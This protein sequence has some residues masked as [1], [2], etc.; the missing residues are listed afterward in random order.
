MEW[1]GAGLI[2]KRLLVCTVTCNDQPQDQLRSIVVPA[3]PVPIQFPSLEAFILDEE[4]T[5]SPSLSDFNADFN[6]DFGPAKNDFNTDFNSDFS[7]GPDDN[8]YYPRGIDQRAQMPIVADVRWAVPINLISVLS[9]GSALITVNTNGPHGLATNAQIGVQGLGNPA[10]SGSF[11][12]TV[13]TATQFIYF[14]TSSVP[15]A[16]LAN[17]YTRMITLDVG[18]PYGQTSLSPIGATPPT[19]DNLSLNSGGEVI[20]NSG[21]SIRLNT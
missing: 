6:T 21:G 4:G 2:N 12:I 7:S 8:G 3:D 5:S 20:L 9:N 15:T 13:I 16:S 18:L 1:G 11:S 17:N 10:A 14:T 19:G